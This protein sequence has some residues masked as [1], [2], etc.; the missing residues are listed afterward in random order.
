MESLVKD[1]YLNFENI[2]MKQRTNR[3]ITGAAIASMLIASSPV[4]PQDLSK[5]LVPDTV[6]AQ[7]QRTVSFPLK[8][9]EKGA[10]VLPAKLDGKKVPVEFDM[11]NIRK[12]L[13]VSSKLGFAPN[14]EMV[15][16]LAGV[17]KT[18][19]VE[20]S[21]AVKPGRVCLG[22]DFL[23]EFT[24]RVDFKAGTIQFSQDSS[25]VR[26][27]DSILAMQPVFLDG[28]IPALGCIVIE[29][30]IF[31]VN[32]ARV[33]AIPYAKENGITGRDDP[34]GM[35][36]CGEELNGRHILNDDSRKF[37]RRFLFTIEGEEFTV[38]AETLIGKGNAYFILKVA[39]YLRQAGLALSYNFR[40]NELAIIKPG[41]KL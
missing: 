2:V 7:V 3:L 10:I 21:D 9:N 27:T 40:G 26:E 25:V 30:P 13:S 19:A 22:S 14:A 15:L 29:K 17:E 39:T 1:I 18:V 20:A 8:F 12:G 11:R 5:I 31:G 28:G 4:R 36:M 35:P 34:P 37:G 16:E 23:R 38:R 41:G 6:N 33:Y 32:P 24:V